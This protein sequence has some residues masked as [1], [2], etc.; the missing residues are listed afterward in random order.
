MY[1]GSAKEQ[2]DPREW[3]AA[4]GAERRAT[5]AQ[6][7]VGCRRDA[8]GANRCVSALGGYVARLKQQFELSEHLGARRRALFVPK[9]SHINYDKIVAHAPCVD[10]MG[11]V[12]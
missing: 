10:W 1:R 5:A 11:W 7:D 6:V 9:L 12:G 8:R 2:A 4:P 3:H